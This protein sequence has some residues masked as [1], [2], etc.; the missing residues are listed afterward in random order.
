MKIQKE[1]RIPF[2][3]VE[4]VYQDKD[5]VFQQ[6]VLSPPEDMLHLHLPTV[7]EISPLRERF[8]DFV[9]RL[10]EKE[11]DP[12]FSSAYQNYD[13]VQKFYRDEVVNDLYDLF[14]KDYSPEDR[15]NIDTFLQPSQASKLVNIMTRYFDIDGILKGLQETQG[16]LLGN[17]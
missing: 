11:N 12:E 1:T 7:K 16:T 2:G 8:S 14:L 10:M 3:G 15:L 5:G 9:I 4:V 17:E 13:A 6:R